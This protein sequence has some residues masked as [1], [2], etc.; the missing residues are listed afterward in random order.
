[1]DSDNEHIEN[2][3]DQV[4][5]QVDQ[6]DQGVQQQGRRERQ[7]NNHRDPNE[8]KGQRRRLIL[9]PFDNSVNNN[10]VFSSQSF[11]EVSINKFKSEDA[12]Q[13]RLNLK[14]IDIQLIRIITSNQTGANVYS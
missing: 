7:E 10:V 12:Y 13:Y 9:E 5:D 1:M 3:H 4:G 11:S 2:H 6:R 14:Y 8:A